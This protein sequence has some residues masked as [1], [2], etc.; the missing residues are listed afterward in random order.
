MDFGIKGKTALVTGG[1]R[2]LGR[3][4]ALS[5]AGEGVNVSICA[6]GQETLDETVAELEALGVQAHGSVADITVPAQASSAFNEAVA[7]LGPVD[8]L[9]NNAGGSVGTGFQETT[10]EQ[11]EQA[12]RLNLFGGLD[13]IRLALPSMQERGWG[14]IINITSIYGREHGGSFGYMASKAALIA[15]TKHIAL[16]VAADGIC[17]NSVAP[18]S[19][20]FDGGGWDRFVN[21]QPKDV[22]DGFIGTNLPMGRF[23]WPEPV[24]D[25][26]AY[27][28]SDRAD[29]ITGTCFNADG[30]QSKSLI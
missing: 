5:L 1:S 2:G 10:N 24:G 14:R 9:V 17:V 29:L 11:I 20:L 3:Q 7:A 18:G 8:I 30:G 23:G 22:V 13:L 21:G 27:L 12:F 15:A 25:L 26:V 19:I 4:A 28:A 6:R 16:E